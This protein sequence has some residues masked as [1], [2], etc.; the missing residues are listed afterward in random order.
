LSARGASQQRNTRLKNP[1]PQRTQ[2]REPVQHDT[3]QSP[4][5]TLLLRLQ[6]SVGNAAVT[7]FLN[8]QTTRDETSPGRTTKPDPHVQIPSWARTSSADPLPGVSVPGYESQRQTYTEDDRSTFE[9]AL[10][11]REAANTENVAAFA[12]EY[13]ATFVALWG[14]YVSDAI[15]KAGDDS[16]FSFGEKL[17][18]FVVG[19]SLGALAGLALG[20]A[21]PA[22]EFFA[23]KAVGFAA[24]LVGDAIEGEVRSGAVGREQAR[25]ATFGAGFADH[26]RGLVGGTVR[27]LGGVAPYATWVATAPLDDLGRFRIPPLFPE[28][29]PAAIGATVAAAISGG[30]KGGEQFVFSDDDTVIDIALSPGPGRMVAVTQDTVV[31]APGELAQVMGGQQIG[32][33]RGMPVHIR[34]ESDGPDTDRLVAGPNTEPD[35][36]LPKGVAGP[37]SQPADSG[38]DLATLIAAYPLHGPMKIWRTA[39][40]NTTSIS[41][42][43][44]EHLYLAMRAEPGI[45]LHSLVRAIKNEAFDEGR[46]QDETSQSS[47]IPLTNEELAQRLHERLSSSADS[48]AQDLMTE[49]V[50]HMLI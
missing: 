47:S 29:P 1:R 44:I 48:G 22:L 12:S 17:F 45:T 24:D 49:T 26:V 36:A 25:L 15:A 13:A 27:T 34:L 41:G 46:S 23:E 5:D 33:L 38:V 28:V 10:T 16:G 35:N 50:D 30:L 6:Q 7:K 40:G 20:P 37:P 32:T 11:N 4:Q 14:S 3:Q 9:Q 21:G 31:R 19:E 39:D 42:G 18:K 8:R 43:L 2:A